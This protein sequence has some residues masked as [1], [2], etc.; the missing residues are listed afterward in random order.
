MYMYTYPGHLIFLEYDPPEATT[1]I[2]R[3][4]KNTR[5][6]IVEDFD[7]PEATTFRHRGLKNPRPPNFEGL[8]QRGSLV[9]RDGPGPGPG[10]ALMSFT[11]AWVYKTLGL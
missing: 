6:S 5:P 10:P 8:N 1:V 3:G 7:Q 4:L 11:L 2:N 9:F